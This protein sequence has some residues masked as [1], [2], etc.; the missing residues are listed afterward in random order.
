MI[1]TSP[2]KVDSYFKMLRGA[3]TEEQLIETLTGE[4]KGNRYTEAG[5]A[6]HELLAIKD[7]TE[8]ITEDVINYK[9][10]AFDAY[11][12]NEVNST[13]DKK[14]PFEVKG[15][16][17][18]NTKFGEVGIKGYADYIKGNTIYD[19]KTTWRAKDFIDEYQPSLQWQFYLDIFDADFFKYMILLLKDK[20]GIISINDVREIDFKQSGMHDLGSYLTSKLEEFVGYVEDKNLVE[21]FESM[22]IME[23]K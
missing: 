12:I 7:L 22:P 10:F 19:F 2:T 17:S 14:Y 1:R 20:D 5:T 6:I 9:G 15:Y 16:K 8:L 21:Y 18:Y 23:V 4:F 13:I 11:S 3:I